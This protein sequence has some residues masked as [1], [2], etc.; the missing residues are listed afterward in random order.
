MIRMGPE[1]LTNRILPYYLSKKKQG[2]MIH[3]MEMNL[4]KMEIMSE[5]I[6]ECGK[7]WTNQ[8]KEVYNKNECTVYG[9]QPPRVV[10]YT[11]L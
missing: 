3:E 7:T 6:Q 2:D 8:R 10:K 1:K 11:G 5:D 9:K 4:Q